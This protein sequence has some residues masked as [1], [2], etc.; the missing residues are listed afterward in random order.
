MLDRITHS[1][2]IYSIF[3]LKKI[4]SLV[5]DDQFDGSGRNLIFQT[6]Q[7]QRF[8]FVRPWRQLELHQTLINDS[9]IATNRRKLDHKYF[10]L[11]TSPDFFR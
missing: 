2:R 10:V 4:L 7:G 6:S 9:P 5:K 3:T 11:T 1:L 8:V